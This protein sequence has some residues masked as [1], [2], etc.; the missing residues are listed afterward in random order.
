MDHLDGVPG[1]LLVVVVLGMSFSY[2]PQGTATIVVVDGSGLP[3]ILI[4]VEVT[5]GIDVALALLEG[6][7]HVRRGLRPVDQ[8]R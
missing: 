8:P 3:G 4:D 1:H 6:G 2:T 5:L 7:S